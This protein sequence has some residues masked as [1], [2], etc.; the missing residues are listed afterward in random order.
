MTRQDMPPSG[1]ELV[2]L[3]NRDRLVRF[4][5]ARVRGMPPKIWSMTCG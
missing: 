5:R 4:L 2:Y 1:L 3:E